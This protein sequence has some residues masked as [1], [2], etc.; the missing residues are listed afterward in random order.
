MTWGGRF[1]F[2]AAP[3]SLRPAPVSFSM[4]S[5]SITPTCTSEGFSVTVSLLG[6]AGAWG[7]CS[8]Q[9]QRWGFA[10]RKPPSGPRTWSSQKEQGCLPVPRPCGAPSRGVWVALAEPAQRGHCLERQN[11]LSPIAIPKRDTVLLLPRPAPSECRTHGVFLSVGRRC[12]FVGREELG[13]T[14]GCPICW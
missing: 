11:L 9:K 5:T 8:S 10:G 1:N 3:A 13:R 6:D 12:L 7:V 2:P 14:E 4:P